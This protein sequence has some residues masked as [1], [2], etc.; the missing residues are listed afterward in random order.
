M[1]SV[2]VLVPVYQAQAFISETL[3]SLSN[4][5]FRDFQVLVSIDKSDDDTKL[6]TK[7]WSQNHKNI[8]TRI[9][10][11]T[12]RLGFVKN[13]NF[14][15]EKCKTKYFM[16]MPHDDILDKTY[17][18]KMVQCLK[19][20]P[21]ACTAFSDIK[22]FGGWGLLRSKLAIKILEKIHPSTLIIIQTS[23]RGNRFERILEF[24]INHYTGMPF[25]GLVNREVVSDFL[26][27]SENDC[28]NFA[29]DVIWNLQMALKGEL[30]RVPEVL[31]HKRFHGDSINAQW[32]K[33]T[34]DKSKAWMEHC[35][36]CLKIIIRQEF[37]QEEIE[38]LIEASK[39]RLVYSVSLV[40]PK[41]PVYLNNKTKLLVYLNK[42]KLVVYLNKKERASLL[43]TFEKK[44][45]ALSEAENK[46]SFQF[47]L[48]PNV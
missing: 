11:Q 3:N 27:M 48:S 32:N 35:I 1:P 4:Q 37:K 2:S 40:R 15:L 41:L 36:D 21:Q 38:R 16:V 20:H 10:C 33:S 12:H 17:L 22:C 5:V 23:I 47:S 24:L 46:P 42:T 31:Y 18:Q 28:S 43:E 6:I 30:I 34:K 25:R 8:T 19:V 7:N 45:V 26:L 13:I 14:L 9:F 44:I 39:L 29:I